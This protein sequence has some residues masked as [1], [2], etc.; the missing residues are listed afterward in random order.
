MSQAAPDYNDL[1]GPFLIGAFLDVFFLGIVMLQSHSYFR[2]CQE[3]KKLYQYSVAFLYLVAVLHTTTAC[4]STYERFV[5][6]YA[7][8]EFLLVAGWS[9]TTGASLTGITAFI[10]QSWY[11]YRVYVVSGRKKLLPA[12][13]LLFSFASVGF[14]IACTV[15]GTHLKYFPRFVEFTYGVLIWLYGSIAADIL[16]TVSLVFYLRKAS[17]RTEFHETRSLLGL[18]AANVVENNLLTMIWACIDAILFQAS[19]TAWHVAMNDS[20]SKIYF[21][22]L[23]TSLNARRRI[24]S[25]VQRRRPSLG[26]PSSP[27]MGRSTLTGQQTRNTPAPVALA[28]GLIRTVSRVSER[29]VPLGQ[30]EKAKGGTLSTPIEVSLTREISTSEMI[31]EPE[32]EFERY[33]RSSLQRPKAATTPTLKLQEIPFRNDSDRLSSSSLRDSGS[34]SSEK[35]AIL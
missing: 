22:S 20:L 5:L 14:S 23:L 4:Y 25:D 28:Q 11:A 6:N 3:D 15:V 10:V 18:I 31:I 34:Q 27:G 9:F 19:K 26:G 30:G 24:S 21:L 13:I 33:N 1:I 35:L 32:P 17:E 7:N 2:K 16:I 12:V 8:P 29:L